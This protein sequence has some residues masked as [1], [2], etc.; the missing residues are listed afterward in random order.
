MTSIFKIY[1]IINDGQNM[2]KIQQ[3][4]VATVNYKN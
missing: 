2:T 1:T 3:D 4:I